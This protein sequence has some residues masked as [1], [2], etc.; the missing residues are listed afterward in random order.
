LLL[1]FFSR[2]LL[3]VSYLRICSV[4]PNFFSEFKDVGSLV[5]QD[6][7]KLS[8]EGFKKLYYTLGITVIV[9]DKMGSTCKQIRNTHPSFYQKLKGRGQAE[10]EG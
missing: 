8:T 5:L 3:F 2:L 4:K 6:A 1:P 9:E 10:T 7:N